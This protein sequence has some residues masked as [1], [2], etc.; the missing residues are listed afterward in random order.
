MAEQ[1][2][3]AVSNKKRMF[4]TDV[5]QLLS[6]LSTTVQR[7]P[8]RLPKQI[9][10][11]FI[12]IEQLWSQFREHPQELDINHSETLG[13]PNELIAE[14]T[15][16]AIEL[17]E[18]MDNADNDEYPNHLSIGSINNVGMSC[19]RRCF[20]VA[21][22]GK[23]N[24]EQPAYPYIQ[25]NTVL[26]DY[27]KDLFLRL[28]AA[29]LHHQLLPLYFAGLLQLCCYTKFVGFNVAFPLDNIHWRQFYD[30][31]YELIKDSHIQPPNDK[32]YW[33]NQNAKS[34]NPHQ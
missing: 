26:L 16:K 33:Q 22:K 3:G 9:F 14:L 31:I 19:L 34:T 18:M 7:I 11:T 24:L 28:Y 5:K 4:S 2:Y 13:L 25:V 12:Q 30:A 21:V 20:F 23:F 32:R 15:E 27:L 6:T 8:L 29:N 1:V 10:H 17:T